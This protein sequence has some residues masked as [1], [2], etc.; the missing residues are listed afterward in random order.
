MERVVTP[1][2][3]M[4]ISQRIFAFQH[5]EGMNT[6]HQ[7]LFMLVGVKRETDET[8]TPVTS[9]PLQPNLAPYPGK[10]AACPAAPSDSDLVPGVYEGGL[11]VW[12]ASIDLVKYLASSLSTICKGEGATGEPGR[13]N[14]LEVCGGII[15]CILHLG[16]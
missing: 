11:K 10:H 13:K 5:G 4:A 16:D 14:A 9:F 6:R 2:S 8:T 7:P 1:N 12:E 3:I 15:T